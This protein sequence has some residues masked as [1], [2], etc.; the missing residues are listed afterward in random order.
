MIYSNFKTIFEKLKNLFNP[1][2]SQKISKLN[3]SIDG[4]EL[5][6][7]FDKLKTDLDRDIVMHWVKN[8]KLTQ[9]KIDNDGDYYINMNQ[10]YKND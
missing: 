7:N 8:Q 9:I 4:L 10:K 2:G 5:P 6:E 1:K 3:N